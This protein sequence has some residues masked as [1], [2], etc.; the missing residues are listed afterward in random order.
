[1]DI[2]PLYTKVEK[3]LRTQLG[4]I[5]LESAGGFPIHESNLYLVSPKG[6]I[7]WKAEKPEL[8]TM[9]SRVALNA[10]GET[11]SAYTTGGHGCDLDLKTG[12][13]IKQ[14]RIQ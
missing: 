2:E 11:L 5:V 6:K 10:D 14:T 1:M 13:L 12:K 8:H 3:S 4:D 9:F 7:L